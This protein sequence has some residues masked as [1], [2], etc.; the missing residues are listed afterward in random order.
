PAPT[1]SGKDTVLGLNDLKQKSLS[2]TQ[3]FYRTDLPS[4]PGKLLYEPSTPKPVL[5]SFQLIRTGQEVRIVDADGSVYAG[6]VQPPVSTPTPILSA[7]EKKQLLLDK[8]LAVPETNSDQ[9]SAKTTGPA[10]PLQ[11]YLFQVA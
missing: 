7:G 8:V 10:P 11:N 4:E 1:L 9:K 2:S 6:Y 5:A 3:R